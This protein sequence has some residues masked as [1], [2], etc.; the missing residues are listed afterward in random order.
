[1]YSTIYVMYLCIKSMRAFLWRTSHNITQP[2]AHNLY[3]N[4]NYLEDHLGATN[5]LL[6]QFD[7]KLKHIN[8]VKATTNLR[9]NSTYHNW[10]I[11][12]VIKRNQINNW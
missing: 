9:V 4:S 1:M 12:C 3:K 7:P 8:D 11:K 10:N 6:R 5:Q 2:T